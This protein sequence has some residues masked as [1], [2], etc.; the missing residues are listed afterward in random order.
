M[1]PVL[2][3]KPPRALVRAMNPVLR[4]VLRTPLGWLVRPFGLLEFTGRRS[5]RRYRVPVGVHLVDGIP[6]VF[7]PASWRANFAGGR[8]LTVHLHGSA[9]EMVGRLET[10]P[11]AVAALLQRLFDDGTAPTKVGLRVSPGHRIGPDDV[12]SVDRAAVTLMPH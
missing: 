7:T 8:P 11:G 10:E 2:D 6:V 1:N 3:A 12:A 5:G 9:E 4:V